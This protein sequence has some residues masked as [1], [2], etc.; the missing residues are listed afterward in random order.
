MLTLKWFYTRSRL[1]QLGQ[2]FV[3]VFFCL[4]G[5]PGVVMAQTPPDGE[6]RL[7]IPPNPDGPTEVFI[8]LGIRD[9]SRIDEREQVFEIDAELIAEWWDDRLTFDP[10][11][12]GDVEK[13]YQGEVALEKLK[14]E[15]WWP[16]LEITDSRGP[17][18][19]MG[20][21]LRV[22]SDG[23]VFYRER[24][25]VLIG[26]PF[27]LEEFP[28]DEHVISLTVEPFSHSADRVTFVQPEE[29]RLE[30]GWETNEWAISNDTLVVDPGSLEGE[31]AYPYASAT[32]EITIS[33]IPEF[34]ISNFILPLLLIVA[35]S[36]AVFWMD[37]ESMHLADRL[38]VSFTS[39]LTVV[40]FDF[41]TSDSLPKLPYSTRLDNMLTVS[42]IFLALTVLENVIGHTMM[43]KGNMAAS[44]RIDKVSR[45][46][47]P[48]FYYILVALVMI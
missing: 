1:T 22:S 47:F 40:A 8:D 37:F 30:L 46:L 15:I 24:F 16:D 10:E 18:D 44:Q 34:Y 28:F 6:A 45:W 43:K 4:I 31:D 48:A 39:V 32:L 42:Y 13:V 38:S 14:T 12:F 2:L 29:T 23:Y 33:R 17:R 11:N 19:R 26:Q 9:I 3:L 36:W 35:I 5:A 21:E 25:R 7:V 41:V 20:I 27:F